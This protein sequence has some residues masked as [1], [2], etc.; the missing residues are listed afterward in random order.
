MADPKSTSDSRAAVREQSDAAPETG[1]RLETEI[2]FV[3]D[4]DPPTATPPIVLP[5]PPGLVTAEERAAEQSTSEE[6]AA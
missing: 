6:K 2:A 5:R 4:F 3:G 1:Y